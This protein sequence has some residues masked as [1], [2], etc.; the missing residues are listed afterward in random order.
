MLLD[1]I[2]HG[3]ELKTNEESLS[4]VVK[5]AFVSE[6]LEKM[7]M[8]VVVQ[9]EDDN[10]VELGALVIHLLE[11]IQFNTHPIDQVRFH[12]LTAGVSTFL[13]GTGFERK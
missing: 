9:E 5:A 8:N 10:R 1:M 3:D 13:R 7:D 2:S 4:L 11:V 12:Q 6:I